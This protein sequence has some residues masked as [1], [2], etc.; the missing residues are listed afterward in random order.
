MALKKK[1]SFFESAERAF[2]LF[3]IFMAK[4][5][6]LKNPWALFL[7][8]TAG[9]LVTWT[10]I[11]NAFHYAFYDVPVVSNMLQTTFPP[12]DITHRVA[13]YVLCSYLTYVLLKPF[14]RGLVVTH[15]NYFNEGSFR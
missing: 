5:M 2:R 9:G 1:R 8:P 6:T 11:P 13:A 7:A 10:L 12:A 14:C 4:D 15:P 3:V